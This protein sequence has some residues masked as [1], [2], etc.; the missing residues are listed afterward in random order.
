MNRQINQDHSQLLF[1]LERNAA[2]LRAHLVRKEER[3][4]NHARLETERII[5]M[6]STPVAVPLGHPRRSRVVRK[7]VTGRTPFYLTVLEICNG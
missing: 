1:R 4:R 7:H 6:I 3:A 5:R 2:I